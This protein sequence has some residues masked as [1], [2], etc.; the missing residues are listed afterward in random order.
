MLSS[1][2]FSTAFAE[3]DAPPRTLVEGAYL[4]LRRD[5]VE[6]RLQPGEKLRV[7]H[8]KDN[9]EVGAGTL[10]E[11]LALLLSDALVVAEGQRGFRVA[12]ISMAD[13]ADLT[14][15]R[16]LLETE[17]LRRSI[18]HGDARWA[19]ELTAA[20]DD[21]TRIEDKLGNRASPKV[22]KWETLN[23]NFH[24]ALIAGY[25]SPW[26]RYMLGILYRQ[27]ERY[28]RIALI[29]RTQ[30]RDVH[31]EHTEI[32]ECAIERDARRACA[33][34]EKHIRLTLEILQ[35]PEETN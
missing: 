35:A 29:S 30:P 22:R 20:F 4:Q 28:R 11:A 9:Y 33:A 2:R 21:L 12:P 24:E 10:R 23:R 15:T 32:Y 34:L 5:I 26:L 17:A 16:I 13:L 31:A 8:L 18:R 14:R 27:S 3:D 1:R 6:G 25:E 7:E 19:A